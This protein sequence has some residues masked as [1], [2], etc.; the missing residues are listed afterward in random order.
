L[1]RCD[2]C[3]S[4][5]YEF[6]RAI[7]LMASA[8]EDELPDSIPS[9]HL[10]RRI[11]AALAGDSIPERSS[12]RLSFWRQMMDAQMARLNTWGLS[13]RGLAYASFGLL[14]LVFGLW[15]SVRT[16]LFSQKQ[17]GRAEIQKIEEP[18]PGPA[19]TPGDR[20]EDQQVAEE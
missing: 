19:P 16:G 5:A 7:E 4:D 11:A 13:P 1:T 3:A 12:P 8:F 9:E 18:T 2:S 14:V 6:E 15:L 10:R 17:E 20:R